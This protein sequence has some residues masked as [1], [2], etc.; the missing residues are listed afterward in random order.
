ME[1]I[2]QKVERNQR[3]L[4]LSLLAVFL[5]GIL[6]HGYGFMHSSF[7]HDSLNEFNG[8]NGGDAW[9]IQLGRFVIP[10]YKAVFR[11]DLT[12]PWLVGI[13]SLLWIGLSVFLVIRIFKIESRL[14]VFLI[15]GIFTANITVAATSATYMHDFDCD[16]FALLCSVLAVHFWKNVR[17]GGTFGA[18]FVAISLGIYQS[19]LSVTIVLVMFVC[20]LDLLGEKGFKSVLAAGLKAVGMLLL[21]CVIYYAVMR[22]VL[23]LTGIELASGDSNNL[24]KMLE[25]TPRSILSLIYCAYQ[26]CY[27][28]LVSAVS[29]Y[30]AGLVKGA[31][32]VMLLMAAGALLAGLWNKRLSA[33]DKLLC[34]GL[35]A[36][37]PLGMNLMY[38]LTGGVVHDLMVYAV[39]LFYLLVLLLLNRWH[40]PKSRMLKGLCKALI[41]VL[42]YGNVQT[43]NALYLKKDMEQKAFLSLMTRVVYRMEECNEYEPGKTPVVFVGNSDQ[44]NES[45]SGFEKYRRITG[46]GDARSANM[47]ED[48]RSRTYFQYVLN[49]PA[50][51]AS[52]SVWEE[53]QT[54]P[55]V[56]EM[57][58]YPSD[59]CIAMLDGVLVVKLG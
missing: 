3:W 48:F 1:R 53:M 49:N 24:D 13:L 50:L 36:L 2:A 44:L 45:I 38:V 7:S 4:L 9:K 26:D 12:L 8:A 58:S 10:A 28:R 5:W 11:T 56:S 35:V 6:A 51:I 30:P 23:S 19:Y 18:I 21:G 43:A 40:F 20:I 42:L 54:D 22:L 16:M 37:L 33:L 55:R 14:L 32:W 59:G 52:G 41:F 57:P 25:L 31:T 39:W 34:V 47:P 17:G 29:P 27:S 15:A 46:A